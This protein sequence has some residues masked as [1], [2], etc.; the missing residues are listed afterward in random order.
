[1][2]NNATVLFQTRFINGM[3]TVIRTT[4]DSK[5][6]TIEQDKSDEVHASKQKK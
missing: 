1:M 2:F 3:S 5:K 6:R 4:H